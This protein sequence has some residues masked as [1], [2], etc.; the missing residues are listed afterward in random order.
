MESKKDEVTISDG[1]AA[2]TQTVT[3]TATPANTNVENDFDPQFDL[4]LMLR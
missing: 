4:E 3:Q 1:D 2:K